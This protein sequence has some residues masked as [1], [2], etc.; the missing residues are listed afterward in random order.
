MPGGLRDLLRELFAEHLAEPLGCTLEVDAL[1]RVV[2]VAHSGGYQ[3]AAG[4]LAL[5]DVP[6]VTE[7]DL[8]DALYGADDVFLR[9]IASQAPRFD[10]RVA[11]SAA[12]RRPLHLLRRNGRRLPAPRAARRATRSHAAGLSGALCRDD[13]GEAGRGA[14]A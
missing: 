4:A 3:A 8:L 13:D 2:L 14:A 11:R 5:G 7:V 12:V 10:P 6:R 1:D 9:W